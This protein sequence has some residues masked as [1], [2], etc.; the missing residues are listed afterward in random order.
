VIIHPTKPELE[1]IAARLGMNKLQ[2][3]KHRQF[4]KDI[5]QAAIYTAV[6]RAYPAAI[7]HEISLVLAKRNPAPASPFKVRAG[8][9]TGVAIRQF[10]DSPEPFITVDP[11]TLMEK[12]LQ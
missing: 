9:T 2:A 7:E 4:L 10:Q 5:W 6:Q 1:S 12:A 8:P 3:H 11:K